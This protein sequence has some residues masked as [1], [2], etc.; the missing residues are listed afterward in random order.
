MK[1]LQKIMNELATW[2]SVILCVAMMVILLANVILRFIPG[3]GGFSWYMESSQYLNVWSMLIAGIAIS[4]ERSHL[5]VAAVDDLTLKV[6]PTLHKIQQGIVAAGIIVFYLV[7]AYSGAVYA[8]KSKQAISTMP[9]LK[10]GMVYWMFPVAGVLSAI[11]AAV[12]YI[13]FLLD[14][15]GGAKE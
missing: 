11:S 13:V 4:A 8:S 14:F 5:K 1:K 10:M 9:S 2:I 12:D 3:I 7:M 15:K 6:N